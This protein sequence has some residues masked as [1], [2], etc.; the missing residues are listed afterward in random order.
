MNQENPHGDFSVANDQ[1]IHTTNLH[2]RGRERTGVVLYV[3]ETHDGKM[4]V[5]P[6]SIKVTSST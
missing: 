2:S 1:S 6:F 5:I 4:M 3:Q